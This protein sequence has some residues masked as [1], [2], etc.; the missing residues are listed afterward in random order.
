MV[1]CLV[2]VHVAL[3]GAFLQFEGF[4]LQIIQLC[5]IREKTRKENCILDWRRNSHRSA[6]KPQRQAQWLKISPCTTQL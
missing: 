4:N 5:V 1:F 6:S 3:Y 2:L